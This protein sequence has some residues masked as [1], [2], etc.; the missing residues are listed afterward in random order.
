MQWCSFVPKCWQHRSQLSKSKWR[1]RITTLWRSTKH[2]HIRQ[3]AIAH[4]GC[5]SA[6][7]GSTLQSTPSGSNP[8]KTYFRS[9]TSTQEK[10][11]QLGRP[12]GPGDLGM[13]WCAPTPRRG[14]HQ[15]ATR[16]NEE[17]E[18]AWTT[19]RLTAGEFN[20]WRRRL[21]SESEV[22]SLMRLL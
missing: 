14:A 9:K 6:V 20:T 15:M 1:W 19:E 2:L 8:S 17:E 5:S 22:T 4:S 10:L 12:I 7:M 13:K 3:F 11:E 16:L 21:F 18:P